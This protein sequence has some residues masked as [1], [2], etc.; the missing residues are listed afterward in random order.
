MLTMGTSKFA[1]RTTTVVVEAHLQNRCFNLEPKAAAATK[2]ASSNVK[3]GDNAGNVSLLA[4][5]YSGTSRLSD[6]TMW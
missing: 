6:E 5:N 3:M 1:Q 4:S 2:C